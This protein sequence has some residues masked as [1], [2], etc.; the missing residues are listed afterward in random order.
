M[1]AL[2]ILTIALIAAVA[3][4]VWLTRKPT[5]DANWSPDQK[6]LPYADIAGDMVTIHNIRDFKYAS[7]SNYVPRYYDQSFDLARIRSVDYVFEPFVSRPFTSFRGLAHTFLSFGFDDGSYVSISVEVRKK[8]G[9]KFSPYKVLYKHYELMYVIADENDVIDLRANHRHDRVYVYPLKASRDQL[10][11][12]FLSMV[13]RANSLAERPEF[14]NAFTNSC[15]SNIVTHLH[16]IALARVP[17]SYKIV[18]PG[19]SDRLVYDLGLI[20]TGMSFEETRARFLINDM[21]E[22]HRDSPDFSAKIRQRLVSAQAESPAFD[23]R[24]DIIRR[25]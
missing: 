2:I 13:E 16:E 17:F 21:A 7:T 19:Y 14:Y 9:Q 23:P 10:C 1:T 20:D 4:L 24:L 11:R 3:L 6:V 18:F 22:L 8:V 5:N 25:G 12:L 15:T